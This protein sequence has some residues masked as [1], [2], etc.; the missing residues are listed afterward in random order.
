MA[1]ETYQLP[2]VSNA[3]KMA[4]LNGAIAVGPPAGAWNG[5]KAIL[6]TNQ[7]QPS[8]QTKLADLIQ[9]TAAE[10]AAYA[11]LAVTWNAPY[12]SGLNTVEIDAVSVQFKT[13]A[14]DPGCIVYGYGL[15][16]SAGAVLLWSEN[17]PAPVQL[18][19]GLDAITLVVGQTR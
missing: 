10:I 14:A 17:F 1:V 4:E 2:V 6:Y 19:P 7:I 18:G 12:E 8:A 9:P 15:M 5:G 11:A 3:S 13:A 16:D